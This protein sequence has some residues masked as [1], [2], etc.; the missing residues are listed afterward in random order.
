MSRQYDVVIFD[1][2]NTLI[3]FSDAR[4]FRRFLQDMQPLRRVSTA[5]GRAL[6]DRWNAVF[7][8][9]RHEARGKGARDGELE[10]FWRAVIRDVCAPL[11]EPEAAAAELERRFDRG[12]LQQLYADVRPALAA[13]RARGVPM[14]IISNFRASLEDYLKELRIGRYFRFVVCYAVVGLAKPDPAIF[15]LGVAQAGC[16]AERILYVGDD[17]SDD[18]E[19]AT[20]AGLGAVLLDRDDWYRNFPSP[21]IRTLDE[22]HS[23]L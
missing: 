7:R 13:L 3:G 16:R 2:G 10:H 12:D 15:R 14:G 5:E 20:R 18:V 8:Q 22:L 19:G 11:P 6:L 1:V 17:P 4:P 9:R 23:F 21:R